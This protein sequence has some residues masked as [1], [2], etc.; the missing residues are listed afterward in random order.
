AQRRVHN[1]CETPSAYNPESVHAVCAHPHFLKR[2]FLI[3]AGSSWRRGPGQFAPGY[4]HYSIL[5]VVQGHPVLGGW[6]L[7]ER[8]GSTC[9]HRPCIGPNAIPWGDERPR[10]GHFRTRVG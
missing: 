9:Q 7:W 2:L 6:E 3:S 5:Q 10:T 8:R 1:P 4:L